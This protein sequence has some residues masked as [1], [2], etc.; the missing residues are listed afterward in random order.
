MPVQKEIAH[1]DDSSPSGKNRVGATWQIL[2]VEPV[3][4]AKGVQHLA[5]DKLRLDVPAP[6][7]VHLLASLAPDKRIHID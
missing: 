3:S 1:E 7:A 6:N 2:P 5:N 4:I